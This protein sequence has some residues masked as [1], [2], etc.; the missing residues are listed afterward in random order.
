MIQLDRVDGWSV[1]SVGFDCP[2]PHHNG[3]EEENDGI[4]IEID[5]RK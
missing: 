1:G 4:G 5:T 3:K 2:H